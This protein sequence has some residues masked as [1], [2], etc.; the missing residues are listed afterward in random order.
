MGASD[1]DGFVDGLSDALGLGAR[2][3]HWLRRRAHRQPGLQRFLL[4]ERAVSTP[5][6]ASTSI[7]WAHPE[8]L[9]LRPS[10]WS[11]AEYVE[12]LRA[13]LG[14]PNY[15]IPARASF[16]GLTA[17]EEQTA[18][19]QTQSLYFLCQRI[20]FSQSV[21]ANSI[22][23]RIRQAEKFPLSGDT[24]V[25][26]QVQFGTAE[27]WMPMIT[28]FTPREPLSIDMLCEGTPGAAH[29]VDFAAHGW[30]LGGNIDGA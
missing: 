4:R 22:I 29:N 10:G 28:L 24:R 13:A 16:G 17:N 11:Q 19:L 30:L 25:R 20:V 5:D 14:S 27:H 8:L 23:A 3:R 26:L 18:Q 2:G 1:V 9:G 21:A 15:R 7:P 12:A 6:L